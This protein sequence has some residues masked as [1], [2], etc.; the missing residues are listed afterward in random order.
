MGKGC[1]MR[2]SLFAVAVAAALT[3][4]AWSPREA[5]AQI[6]V[7]PTINTSPYYY[8]NYYPSYYSGYRYTYPSYSYYNWTTPYSSYYGSRYTYPGYSYQSYYNSG[9]YGRGG[10]GR[11]HRR[12]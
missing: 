11:W 3:V 8:G 5:Q 2:A 10:F 4:T 7:F 6:R 12:W 9:M 1:A